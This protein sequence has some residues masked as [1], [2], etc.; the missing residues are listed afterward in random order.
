MYFTIELGIEFLA[1]LFLEYESENLPVG[2]QAASLLG[3]TKPP[4]TFTPNLLQPPFKETVEIVL[5]GTL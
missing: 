3:P 2:P 4:T 1:R 5:R